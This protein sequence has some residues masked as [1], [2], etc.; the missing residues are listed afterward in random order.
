LVRLVWGRK[1]IFQEHFHKAMRDPPPRTRDFSWE[2]LQ[3]Q[4]PDLSSL[5][6]H[7]KGDLQMPDLSSLDIHR[8]GDLARHPSNAPKQSA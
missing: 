8:K 5:D 3:L 4:M 6:I 7:R 2:H 1:R